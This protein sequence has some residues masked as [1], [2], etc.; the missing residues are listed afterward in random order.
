MA[1]DGDLSLAGDLNCNDATVRG[2][3]YAANIVPPPPSGSGAVL[4][5][6]I[7]PP[8]LPAG[9]TNDYAPAGWATSPVVRVTPDPVAGSTITG[10]LALPEGTIRVIKNVGAQ[11]LIISGFDALSAAANRIAVPIGATNRVTIPPNGSYEF[12]YDAT[13]IR[14][15]GLSNILGQLSRLETIKSAYGF[16]ML[17]AA[18]PTGPTENWAPTSGARDSNNTTLIRVVTQT[19]GSI[20]G[21]LVGGTVGDIVILENH[22]DGSGARANGQLQLLNRSAGSA[23]GNQFVLPDLADLIIPYTGSITLYYDS[24]VV[25][26]IPI[27]LSVNGFFQSAT[28]GQLDLN[29]LEPAPLAVGNNND[30]NAP[31]SVDPYIGSSLATHSAVRVTEAGA[32]AVL[33]GLAANLPAGASAYLNGM[34]KLL[35]NSGAASFEVSDENVASA[36]LN[37]FAL[38]AGS[39][40][41]PP[42]Q[43]LLMI[44][45]FTSA[46]W[47]V[48]SVPGVSSKQTLISSITDFALPAAVNDYNPAGFATTQRLRLA[49][50]AATN[51]SGMVAQEDGAQR[52]ITAYGPGLTILHQSALSIAPNRFF[53]PGAANLVMAAGQS[54]QFN[55]DAVFGA[56]FAA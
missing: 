43:V 35:E 21:G 30:W 11:D 37:R 22:G 8:A 24:A 1:Q 46:R 31:G 47:R 38:P 50:A 34:V 2:T 49:P 29:T 53:L 27:A 13:T 20:L 28:I 55:Y 16:G 15:T 7:S 54:Q 14:W 40:L 52:T 18:L 26:W 48:V 45:D 33:T 42:G 6:W 12:I 56:W 19:F 25:G 44:Y 9:N 5:P 51:L 32:G 10:F 3:L 17:P 39:F 23:V 4:S 41:S 36:A